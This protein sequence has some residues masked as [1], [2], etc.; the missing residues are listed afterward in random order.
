MRD[1]GERNCET[2]VAGKILFLSEKSQVIG[3]QIGKGFCPKTFWIQRP[4]L[5]SYSITQQKRTNDFI[6]AKC[7]KLSFILPWSTLSTKDLFHFK[8]TAFLW[9]PVKFRTIEGG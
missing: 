5:F 7:G 6:G 2:Y 9:V 8:T 3:N 4:P 1:W